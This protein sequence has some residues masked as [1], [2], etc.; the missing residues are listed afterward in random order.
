MARRPVCTAD[1]DHA[2]Q[3]FSFENVRWLEPTCTA[4]PPHCVNI[5]IRW[6][7]P[8][9]EGRSRERQSTP[10]KATD[11]LTTSTMHIVE[12]SDKLHVP[13]RCR[14]RIVSHMHVGA[15]A[16]HKDRSPCGGGE[17][18]LAGVAAYLVL[19]RSPASKY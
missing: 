9:N 7:K 15:I 16:C 14:P 10:R 11:P 5:L 2:N 4:A 18:H 3:F 8:V 12:A 19:S 1:A 6:V 17:P 13:L